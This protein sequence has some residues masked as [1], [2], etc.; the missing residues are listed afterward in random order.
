MAV[1]DISKDEILIE[2]PDSVVLAADEEDLDEEDESSAVCGAAVELD[3]EYDA[4]TYSE[5]FP[6]TAYVMET[7]TLQEHDGVLPIYWSLEGMGWIG[8]LVGG[9]LEP[10]GFGIIGNYNAL[11]Y[12]EEYEDYNPMEKKQIQRAFYHVLT[13]GSRDMLVPVLDMIQHQQQSP[14]VKQI[15]RLDKSMSNNKETTTTTTGVN[16]NTP[17]MPQTRSSTTPDAAGPAAV[18]DAADDDDDEI[19]KHTIVATRDIRKGEALYYSHHTTPEIFLL[20]GFVEPY[21]QRWVFHTGYDAWHIPPAVPVAEDQNASKNNNGKATRATSGFEVNKENPAIVSFL[22]DQLSDGSDKNDQPRFQVTWLSNDGERPSVRQLSW[23]VA[24]RRRL[25]A[26]NITEAPLTSNVKEKEISS[27]YYEALLN[28]LD[29]AVLW[30]YGYDPQNDD[31]DHDREDKTCSYPTDV[32]SSVRIQSVENLLL[33]NQLKTYKEDMVSSGQTCPGPLVTTSDDKNDKNREDQN[34]HRYDTLLE[35]SDLSLYNKAP[36]SHQ[37]LIENY[38]SLAMRDRISSEY[39]LVD[40]THFQGLYLEN[41][42]ET[43]LH[44]DGILHSCSAFRP[45]VHETIIH[46]PASYVD[47]VKRVLYVGGGDLIILHEILKYPS[48]ELVIGTWKLV[49]IR[50][51]E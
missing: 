4:R 28:A 31:D 48:L 23:L 9:E 42:N 46:Y 20:Y 34:I 36:V 12:D 11:C 37:C 7:I 8:N 45:H 2:V 27:E 6:Y 33:P 10:Q 3:L 17:N 51:V 22:L 1:E 44:L 25:R 32:T 41:T 38:G 18:D 30:A 29:Q 14:N 24:H 39:Q 19:G 13:M 49:A 15:L 16:K 40:W 47:E 21:P 43:C 35:Q 26:M 50:V 5:F